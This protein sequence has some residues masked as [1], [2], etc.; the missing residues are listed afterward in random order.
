MAVPSAHAQTLEWVRQLGTAEAEFA[1][2]VAADSLGNVYIA[3]NTE[4]ILGGPNAGGF[5]AFVSKYDATGNPAWTRQ[6]ASTAVAYYSSVSVDGLGNVYL[7]GTVRSIFGTAF[8]TK[9]DAAG[10]LLW[11]R[12]VDSAAPSEGAGVSVDSLGNVYI[13]GWTGGNLGGPNAGSWDAFV[14]KYD[15]AGTPL[16]T[17]QYGTTGFDVPRAVSADTLGNVYIAGY[18]DDG[19][20]PPGSPPID[21]F[22]SKF[23]EA[24]ALQWT[25]RLGAGSGQHIGQSVSTDALGNVYF[26]GSTDKSLGGPSAGSTDVFLFKY[27]AAGNLQWSRQ[28]GTAT[29]E[30]AGSVSADDLGNVYLAGG[31]QGSLVGGPD[32]GL[33]RADVFL[34]KFNAAGDRQWTQQLGT[35]TTDYS[36][37]VAAD[38][39]GNVYIAGATYGDL[40]GPNTGGSAD[41]FIAKYNDFIIPEPATG[42][43]VAIA[44]LLF[45]TRRNRTYR[46]RFNDLAKRRITKSV[47]ALIVICLAVPSTAHGA[48][49][50]ESATLG[51]T[52]LDP[53]P[54]IGM[55]PS[56]AFLG[57]RFSVDSTVQ[58]G[59]VGGHFIGSGTIFAAIVPLSSATALPSGRPTSDPPDGLNA[60][61][62]AVINLPFPS[63][64][65]FAPLSLTLEPGHYAL[66]F[67][68]A[69]YGTAGSGNMLANGVDIP[70]AASYFYAIQGEP[71]EGWHDFP[72]VGGVVFPRPPVEGGLRFIV[73]DTVIPEPATWLLAAVAVVFLQMRRKKSRTMSCELVAAL[74]LA[75]LLPTPPVQAETLDGHDDPFEDCISSR[76]SSSER[77]I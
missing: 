30:A 22:I 16:W 18:V 8:V 72:Y 17:S 2:G 5:E 60:L 62:T 28:F 11:T 27:D 42:L 48:F 34:T 12:Q 53:A 4:G 63:A 19:T 52:G 3:G 32:A 57:S 9:F 58:V 65:V 24:G 39:F 10:D 38:R 68:T 41:V 13:A 76:S 6:L 43:L 25:K 46:T 36:G 44:T 73:S 7:S 77:L 51:P 75:T 69:E 67:G 14:A 23:D 70:G 66:I 31:T 15:A 55:N 56:A 37:G 61:A 33:G 50:H 26:S 71:D 59:S 20:G 47:G 74:A 54:G 35:S 49:I 45:G 64:E 21:A 29:G 40:G 1:A